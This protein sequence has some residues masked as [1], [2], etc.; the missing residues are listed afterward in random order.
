M[1]SG[2]VSRW[3]TMGVGERVGSGEVVEER[4]LRDA[5]GLDQVDS[6]KTPS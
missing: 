2:I 3:K 6:S 4:T 1:P 5:S